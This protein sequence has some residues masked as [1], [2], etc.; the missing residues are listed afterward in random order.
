MPSYTISELMQQMGLNPDV[1][2]TSP[3]TSN[4]QKAEKGSTTMG[5][6]QGRTVEESKALIKNVLSEAKEP[7]TR[8]EIFKAIGRKNTP[9]LRNILSEMVASGDVIEEADLAVSRMMSR[10]WYT[11]AN[12]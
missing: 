7:M 6:V 9:H 8:G 5:R 2:L 11:L 4:S 3:E 10:Y 1:Q 12:R